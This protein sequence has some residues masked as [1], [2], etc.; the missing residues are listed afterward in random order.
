MPKIEPVLGG[1][2]WYAPRWA[3]NNGYGGTASVLY[4]DKDAIKTLRAVPSPKL[5]N[6]HISRYK[7]PFTKVT[8]EIKL[9]KEGA[10]NKVD[11]TDKTVGS[12]VT[13]GA[14]TVDPNEM[15]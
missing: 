15:Q 13:K 10:K 1:A 9:T 11:Y 7:G 4:P 14:K 5:S 12:P 3:A 6:N 2:I 8:G